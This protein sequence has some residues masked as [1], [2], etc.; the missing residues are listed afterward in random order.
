[1]KRKGK[2]IKVRKRNKI[3]VNETVGYKRKLK[4]KEV[5]SV[6]EK[7]GKGK[8]NEEQLLRRGELVKEITK[9]K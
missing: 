1:M 6:C 5:V 2:Q 4:E 9:I 7:E 8:V 3:Q